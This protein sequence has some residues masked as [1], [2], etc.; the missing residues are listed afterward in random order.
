MD[1][2]RVGGVRERRR[3]RGRTVC[4][5]IK[6]PGSADYIARPWAGPAPSGR[7][8]FRDAWS[9]GSAERGLEND[10]APEVIERKAP[11][12][13]ADSDLRGRAPAPHRSR[14]S[15]DVLT[16]DGADCYESGPADF[17]TSVAGPMPSSLRISRRLTSSTRAR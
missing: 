13:E 7:A 15:P 8:Q 11:R 1:D 2:Q 9:Q 14:A 5:A 6:R 10:V 16:R 3:V 17:A 4:I 12:T